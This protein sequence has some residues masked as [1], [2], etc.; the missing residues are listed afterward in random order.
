MSQTQ[1]DPAN[2][3]KQAPSIPVKEEQILTPQPK[4]SQP[5]PPP[6]KPK[7]RIPKLLLILGAIALFAGVGYGVY[8]L[9]FYQP[10]PE[11]LFLSGRI[12]G[13]ETDISAKIGGRIADVY[14]REGDVVKPNQ[15]LVQI[16]DAEVRAQLRGSAAR[17]RAAQERL[18]RARQQLP[19][20]QAQLQQAK[21][22]TQQAGQE[23]QGRVLEVENALAAARFQLAEAQENLTLAAARQRRTS[24]LFAQGAVSAQQRDEDNAALGA[25]KA[26]VA[27]AQEQVKSSQ[28]RLTQAQATRRNQ[29]IRAAAELQIQAQI[30]QARTDI[31]VSQ[32]EVGNA[33][34]TQAE[35]QANLNYLAINSPLT[36]NV[37]TRSVEP[38]E[39][40][41]AGAPLLTIVNLNNL[42]LRGF[43]PEGEIGMVRVGQQG[44]VYLDTFPDRPLQATVTRVDPKAS[45]TPEN[46]YF[47][48]DR[49]TQVFGVELTLKNPQGFAKPGMPADGRILV[50]ET[51]QKRR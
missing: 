32:Q 41:A 20:L 4:T 31:A 17:V 3:S 47:K 10:E 30:A 49:V 43:I 19:V 18:E 14:V 23:S 40:V 44:F 9:F 16:N 37:I 6:Q 33:K 35:I 36:G 42:Y 21:L 45:F 1:T 51:A 29:P 25:A 2:S 46:T 38:G 24:Q 11:G 13:Y 39:V 27:A 28:G 26:R 5:Q 22:T 34:A 50:P 15:L 7:R 8:R 12:E 48:K